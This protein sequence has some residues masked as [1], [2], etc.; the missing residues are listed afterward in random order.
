[1][2]QKYITYI[3]TFIENPTKELAHFQA[4]QT[5][6]LSDDSEYSNDPSIYL[7]RMKDFMLKKGL[8]VKLMSLLSTPVFK[9]FDFSTKR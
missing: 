9:I 8:I 6:R 2:V 1:M 3:Q 7:E 5:L 4:A